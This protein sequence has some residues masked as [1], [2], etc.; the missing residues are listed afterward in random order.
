MA[1][2]VVVSCALLVLIG[3][4]NARSFSG[5]YT[6][7]T[8]TD[9]EGEEFVIG[10]DLFQFGNE[11]GG[12]VRYYS[13][14]DLNLNTPGSLGVFQA[15]ERLCFWSS[16]SDVGDTFELSF[17]DEYGVFN[18]LELTSESDGDRLVGRLIPRPDDTNAYP[19]DADPRRDEVRELRFERAV[20]G[21]ADNR[22][23]IPPEQFRMSLLDVDLELSR[24]AAGEARGSRCLSCVEEGTFCDPRTGECV[25]S[26]LC[27]A[28][29]ECGEGEVCDPYRGGCVTRMPLGRFEAALLWSGNFA[30][31]QVDWARPVSN[32]MDGAHVLD[33][34]LPPGRWGEL[35]PLSSVG[36]GVSVALGVVVVFRNDDAD[37]SE[38]AEGDVEPHI[39]TST[40]LVV[41]TP[42][43]EADEEVCGGTVQGARFG[44]LLLYI[45][46]DLADLE[47]AAELGTPEQ[48]FLDLFPEGALGPIEGY[49][50]YDACFSP[51]TSVV[52]QLSRTTMADAV[53]RLRR[54]PSPEF[55]PLELPRL[56]F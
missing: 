16:R 49:A 50:V 13:P 4:N 7:A 55:A 23:L 19:S 9:S 14:R 45:D 20:E 3:C 54:L 42:F 47:E 17:L 15:E 21:N 5:R 33:R 11:V 46:G 35:V 26:E 44:R 32:F 43:R 39:D 24:S 1:R 40:A 27:D 8:L 37:F 56:L 52:F 38:E 25:E 48:N 36:S 2:W 18:T 6:E 10:L 29:V 41:G 22:C 53:I 31:T 30:N 12:I 34:N 28:E 51:D